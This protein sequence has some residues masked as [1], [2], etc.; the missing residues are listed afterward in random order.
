[1]LVQQAA[2]GGGRGAK[3]VRYLLQRPRLGGQP[4]H[5]IG[6]HAREAESGHS[7]GDTLL[8]SVLA[9]ASQLLAARWLPDVVVGDGAADR[10]LGGAKVGGELGDAPAVVQQRLQTGAHAG[11]AQPPGLLVEAAL[12]GVD[13]REATLNRQAA[14]QTCS[15]WRFPCARCAGP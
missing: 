7:S 13:D 3:L 8:G 10:R 14:R 4:I 2:Q 11:E 15:W 1:V 9:L 6:P 12:L 5:Q